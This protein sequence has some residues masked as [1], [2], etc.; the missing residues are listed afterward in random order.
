MLGGYNRVPKTVPN[1]GLLFALQLY[2]PTQGRRAPVGTVV[3]IE[4]FRIFF[5][6]KVLEVL[7]I[8]V[9]TENFKKKFVTKYYESDTYL[10]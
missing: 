4:I 8:I 3:L 7:I 1:I 5:Y 2:S 9:F 10:Y 6:I